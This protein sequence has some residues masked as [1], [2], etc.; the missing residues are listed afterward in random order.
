MQTLCGGQVR[1]SCH[2]LAT[3]SKRE[4]EESLAADACLGLQFQGHPTALC[5]ACA[6]LLR[7]W[8]KQGA[9]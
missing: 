3:R 8:Q 7:A 5:P 9:R 2:A 1:D 6:W 4:L